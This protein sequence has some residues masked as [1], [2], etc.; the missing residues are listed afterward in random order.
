MENN[1]AMKMQVR[2]LNQEEMKGIY[3]FIRQLNPDMPEDV[4]HE[5][6][7]VMIKKGYRCAAVVDEYGGFLGIAGFWILT[8]FWC[9]THVDI[10]NVVVDERHRGNGIGKLLFA[11][12]EELAR[13]EG[14]TFA[15][16]DAYT[17]NYASHR[18]YFREGYII[19]GYHFTKDL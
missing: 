4:F 3:P 7:E 5:R 9:G 2:E 16:L 13:R 8:R 10:D 14:L 1:M 18:F 6:L 19:R 12:V 15:V 17:T 11:W